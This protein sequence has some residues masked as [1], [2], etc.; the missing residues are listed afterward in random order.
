MRLSR[1]I[2]AVA[3]LVFVLAVLITWQVIDRRNDRHRS[4]PA[5]S[6]NS[7]QNDAQGQDHT[8]DRS[9][10]FD[11]TSTGSELSSRDEQPENGGFQE[12]ASPA[13][14]S[15]QS[16]ADSRHPYRLLNSGKPLN[17][18]IRSEQAIL[19]EN[20]SL[21]TSE[22][23][24][25]DIPDHL[26]SQGPVGAYVVQFDHRLT[27]ADYMRMEVNG[28]RVV[29][30]IP[31]N[32]LLVEGQAQN[33]ESLGHQAGIQTLIPWEPYFKFKE[34]LLE[35]AVKNLP[36]E[37]DQ[38]ISVVGFPGT[39]DTLRAEIESLG[40]RIMVEET[41]P[42]GPAVVIQ[43]DFQDWVK[44]AH[45]AQVMLVEAF[46]P[47]KLANDLARTRL[48]IAPDSLSSTNFLELSG[49]GIVVNVND[50]GVDAT[51]PD[52]QGRVQP[53]DPSDPSSIR[54]F[55]GH[56]TH[57]AGS[58]ASSGLS[59]PGPVEDGEPAAYGSDPEADFRGMAP[60]ASIY[61]LP[62]FLNVGPVQSDTYL[63]EKAA[64]LNYIT[65]GRTDPIISNNSWGYVGL[66]NYSSSSAHFDAAVRD[67]LPGTSGD[68]PIVYLFAAS[69]DGEGDP[70]GLGG[71]P[72]T[73]SAPGN[74]KNVITVG[75]I[76]NFR[77]ITNN[78]TI[79]TGEDAFDLIAP[80]IDD[81][82]SENQIAGFSSRGNTGIGTEGEFGR[83]KPDV[84]APGTYVVST[85]S[86]QY[87]DPTASFDQDIQYVEDQQ[88]VSGRL[89]Q[90][91][92]FIP[93]NAANAT[94]EVLDGNVL[95]NS[96]AFPMPMYAAYGNLPTISDFVGLNRFDLPADVALN[97]GQVLNYAIGNDSGDDQVFTIRIIITLIVPGGG[98]VTD[99]LTQMNDR[100]APHYRYESGTSM[101]TPVVTGLVTLMSEYLQKNNYTQSPA[102]LKALLINGSRT[103]NNIYS[104]NTRSFINFQGWG[105]VNLTNALPSKPFGTEA[106]AVQFLD[107]SIDNALSTGEERSWELT[108]SE[109]ALNNDLRVTLVWTDPPG[110]PSAGVKLVNDLDLV[111]TNLTSTN[112]FF[113][114]DIPDSSDYN[115]PITEQSTADTINNVENIFIRAPLSTNYL[116]TVKGSRV[117][118][119][120][121]REHPNGIVQDFALVVSTANNSITNA[122]SIKPAS[123][124][125]TQAPDPTVITNGFALLNQRTSAHSPLLGGGLGQTNQWKFFIFTNSLMV[126]DNPVLTNGP[127]VAFTTFL[128]PNLSDPKRNL[129]ADVDL[130]VSRG[131]AG[132]LT[133]NPASIANADKSV[134]QGGTE[135]VLYT[136]AV[137][138]EIFYIGVKAEDQKG[139]EFAII[140]I[141]TEQPFSTIDPNGNLR[142]N[143]FPVGRL[144]EDGSPLQPGYEPIIVPSGTDRIIR[145]VQAQISFYSENFGDTLGNLSHNQTFAVLHNHSQDFG[146]P[147]VN[148][149]PNTI[150]TFLYNDS[151]SGQVATVGVRSSDGPGNLTAFIGESTSGPWIYSVFDNAVNNQTRVDSFQL[152][153]EPMEDLLG[154]IINGTVL[155]QRFEY[156][157]FDVPAS[158]TSFEVFLSNI[159]PTLPL[160]LYV[161]REQVP[162]LDEFDKFVGISPPGG[163]LTLS[164]NDSPPLN[165][166][167]YFVGVYNP[168][169]Q[170]VNFSITAVILEDVDGVSFD[171]IT[172]APDQPIPILNHAETQSDLFIGNDERIAE[173]RAGVRVDHPRVSDLTF[174]LI[175]PQ[176]DSFLL[177][178][179]R[180]GVEADKLGISQGDPIN[181]WTNHS[182]AVFTTDTNL[183]TEPLKF[184]DPPFHI[185]PALLQVTNRN[186]LTE[187]FLSLTNGI[188]LRNRSVGSFNVTLGG[189]ELSGTDTEKFLLLGLSDGSSGGIAADFRTRGGADYLVS[190]V[191]ENVNFGRGGVQVYTNG[192]L[193]R[194]DEYVK[195]RPF[196]E[197]SVSFPIKAR[198]SDTTFE[199]RSS[200]RGN[201]AQLK[202]VEITE[203]GVLEDYYMQPEEDFDQLEGKRALGDW[204]LLISDDRSS[205]GQT[206]AEL[207]DW[208][209]EFLFANPD[210]NA[211]TLT[212]GVIY[213][214][215]LTNGFNAY[216][217]VPVPRNATV[218]TN[219]VDGAG[220]LVLLGDRDGIPLGGPGEV[221]YYVDFFG[222]DAGEFLIISTNTPIAAP[223]EPGQVYYLGVS[224]FDPTDT[225]DLPFRIAVFFDADDAFDD[226]LIPELF[227]GV[228]VSSN[229]PAGPEMRYFKFNVE[230]E[231]IQ[232]IISTLPV[233]DNIDL[234]ISKGRLPTFSVYDLASESLGIDADSASLELDPDP[235]LRNQFSISPGTWYVGILN[236]TTTTDINYDITYTEISAQITDLADSVLV[237]ADP[238]AGDAFAYYRFRAPGDAESLFLEVIE[239]SGEIELV[240]VKGAPVPSFSRFD[241]VGTG[242]A[243]GKSVAIDN[244]FSSAI[245]GEWYIAV[246]NIDP[247][248]PVTYKI[249]ASSQLATITSLENKI[250]FEGELGWQGLSQ[251]PIEYFV[252]DISPL[253]ERVLIELT[254]IQGPDNLDLIA[255][256]SLDNG[257][258]GD[259]NFSYRSELPGSMSELITIGPNSLPTPLR[260]G[261]IYIA[262]VHRGT[263]ILADP[264]Q[265]TLTVTEVVTEVQELVV[266]SPL[267]VPDLRSGFGNFY[268]FNI[269][270]NAEAFQV[271][272]TSL[273][274]NVDLYLRKELPLPTDKL[275]DAAG[276]NNGTVSESIQISNYA[277]PLK[278]EPGTYYI[279][280]INR[281][282]TPST[283]TV[284]V[285][286]FVPEIIELESHV[287]VDTN[288]SYLGQ[289]DQYHY[290]SPTNAIAVAWRTLNANLDVDFYLSSTLPYPTTEQFEYSST[291]PGLRREMIFVSTNSLPSPV[292]LNTE[293]PQEWYLSVIK[294][295]P[296]DDGRYG[297]IVDPI[298]GLSDT[299]P[300]TFTNLVRN[301]ATYFQFDVDADVERF[302][303]RV[304]NPT[305]NISLRVDNR[306]DINAGQGFRFSS[307]QSGTQDEAVEIN[308][309][310]QPDGLWYAAVINPSGN[311]ASF[312]IVVEY[313]LPEITDLQNEIPLNAS[314]DESGLNTSYYRFVVPDGSISAKFAIT[315]ISRDL[316]MYLKRGR[317]PLPGPSGFEFISQ[318]PGTSDEMIE[319]TSGSAD[320]PLLPGEYYLAVTQ[321]T[322]NPPHTYTMTAGYVLPPSG[323][324]DEIVDAVPA[325]ENGQV[326]LTWTA[327][328]GRTYRIEGKPTIDSPA[329][330]TLPG[331][332]IIA[333][334]TAGKFCVDVTEIQFVRVV[335]V[336]D[337]NPPIVDEKVIDVTTTTIADGD[338]CFEFT[339]IPGARYRI[340]SRS[341]IVSPWSV[342]FTSG[343]ATT[344]LTKLCVPIAGE[345]IAF[346]QVVQISSE[347]PAVEEKEVDVVS[348]RIVDDQLCFTVE[349]L[350]GARYRVEG[351]TDVSSPWETILTSNPA[352]GGPFEICL[353]PTSTNALFFRIIQ[354]SGKPV[355]PEPGITRPIPV[356]SVSIN[357]ENEFCL[358][359]ATTPG[360][361]Y[362][363][364]VMN[365][366]GGDWVTHSTS[367][368]TSATTGIC[369]PIQ[370]TSEQFFR[371]LELGS[372]VP[373]TPTEITT[374]SISR[375]GNSVCLTWP[376]ADGDTVRV[377]Q[378]TDLGKTWTAIDN[379]SVVRGESTITS[380]HSVTGDTLT[381]FRVLNLN[382]GSGGNPTP[383]VTKPVTISS[384]GLNPEG[385]FCL[386]FPTVVG[387]SYQLQTLASVDADWI[388]QSTLVA[389]NSTSTVCLPLGAPGQQFFRVLELGSPTTEEPVIPKEINS[390]SVSRDEDN[391]CLSWPVAE[392]DNVRV[393]QSTDLGKS[394]S[395]IVGASLT[396]IDSSITFC[397]P[398]DNVDLTLFRVINLSPNNPGNSPGS[399]I[400]VSSVGVQVN[401]TEI[402]LSWPTV[403]GASYKI[404]G[405]KEVDGDWDVINASLPATSEPSLT[406]SLPIASGYRFF[407]IITN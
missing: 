221:D 231:E 272:L 303:V 239:S 399:G 106:T 193:A 1:H 140:G 58:I 182:F 324:V 314:F 309:N 128:A 12:S 246:Y 127:N 380:C 116:I 335:L 40:G 312:E 405:L 359:F 214:G 340:E 311:T 307:N 200:L 343:P 389:V 149:A 50:T 95:V 159:S 385:E 163:S 404:E 175:S 87:V 253:A 19:L 301:T 353:D 310:N 190:F 121:V 321:S 332:I 81:T 291:F 288:S 79:G 158:A 112:T 296:A 294:S 26:R 289:I 319:L 24:D 6:H 2:F 64:E 110:N 322:A 379:A 201:R 367:V 320:F 347:P 142:L 406:W 361:S 139:A 338:I 355:D 124:L 349:S 273:T 57:V 241:L 131:D 17:Q 183:V 133:L 371:V 243:A 176:G 153:V 228:T 152:I 206:N 232:S 48:G 52:L 352:Q 300:V 34:T 295:D 102:L 125:I 250:P 212:N 76:E 211:I 383:G 31:N 195:S 369:L 344:T 111:L 278:V 331:G 264:V 96:D 35:K 155:P 261:P 103:V 318:N 328:P 38:W 249:R 107:Q 208:K 82:D 326:C 317:D 173:I 281:S 395:A 178:E 387:K 192:T 370:T 77:N 194:F 330:Q 376:I 172:L 315:N 351:Q 91:S 145:N 382:P 162:T 181:G 53:G 169:V 93:A 97:P 254:G 252:Y 148:G 61:P 122:I 333:D 283:F 396:R 29:S 260:P 164:R 85:R 185:A 242:D 115:L 165:G 213:S 271:D 21:D 98:N 393:E 191:Y 144:I 166:G 230:D 234:Y 306:F 42:F 60:E 398:A 401:A 41:T 290:L 66:F 9:S 215:V 101:A 304:L 285:Q 334:S 381:L 262:V 207:L 390:L 374:I 135:S 299:A 392:G 16:P 44:I 68:Q 263:D 236:R 292:I 5:I 94:I 54:D 14:D 407:R 391:F 363:I 339:S 233:E 86:G 368:A 358:T 375:V 59:S 199:L 13:R 384:S 210:L 277:G 138:G 25:L 141:S 20:A 100:L 177:A 186:L 89:T 229:I 403:N 161:R 323:G 136:D 286:E 7:S 313:E 327:I 251:T 120:A 240:A 235:Q 36:L 51:H 227:P 365:E 209:L 75:A 119:N 18:L 113:G 23:L 244:S 109:E 279:Q 43:P 293:D 341:D 33:I 130:Y 37:Q 218:A 350:A 255:V 134:S 108:L 10:A 72:D 276:E 49:K 224:R 386:T 402:V 268:R 267:R 55:D 377:E 170:A 204:Q 219:I 245:A 357:E 362:R 394:W 184:L 45:S 168:N 47:R 32:A 74:A 62:I 388:V 188:Y 118:V 15:A 56:G 269:S 256:D 129:S 151:D 257:L 284:L 247:T 88:F 189:V 92:V 78:F 360:K 198:S 259:N 156:Y 346:Y 123:T 216:F 80:F 226:S 364:Q 205:E 223:L 378:S 316:R 248:T 179:A 336:G 280:V 298:Y 302:T 46:H 305:E 275:F 99:A 220:D 114:N 356:D 117:N 83:F 373:A 372:T 265:Y 237:E 73:I 39:S 282:L 70:N 167:R 67:A 187:D 171:V 274:G 4:V 84:V 160:E 146:L 354:L 222:Q 225:R 147:F 217:K 203:V 132:L 104:F 180:G 348:T 342:V 11:L 196:P 71:F 400:Q 258:P 345:S 197:R 63:I 397:Q 238:L 30:Y 3:S 202:Y 65:L 270:T 287:R 143:G 8:P 308:L 325:L 150:D 28:G 266:G 366:L 105:L 297:L 337:T 137:I 174:R 27:Q 329:W 157:V 154:G 69:N 90:Y 126:L 22:P